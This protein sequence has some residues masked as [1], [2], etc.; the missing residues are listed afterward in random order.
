MYEIEKETNLYQIPITNIGTLPLNSQLE[1]VIRGEKKEWRYFFEKKIQNFFH[2]GKDIQTRAKD[3]RLVFPNT[4]HNK[5]YLNL[6][7][8]KV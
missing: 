2:M 5:L 3:F 6:I 1:K 8:L 7:N 4:R